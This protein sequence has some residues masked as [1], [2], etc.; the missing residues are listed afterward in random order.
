MFPR[1]LLRFLHKTEI[2]EFSSIHR[3]VHLGASPNSNWRQFEWFLYKL[4]SSVE[5]QASRA[6]FSRFVTTRFRNN[7]NRPTT[8]VCNLW[9]KRRLSSNPTNVQQL[10]CCESRK[11]KRNWVPNVIGFSGNYWSKTTRLGR[12][13]LK[14]R[15]PE[16]TSIEDLEQC[17]D[18][19]R[20]EEHC[21]WSLPKQIWMVESTNEL[22]ASSGEICRAV[23]PVGCFAWGV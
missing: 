8:L 1:I 5:K 13:L 4:T 2:I 15:G 22:L 11:T 14:K 20:S 6:E 12:V 19:D 9:R 10:N 7:G 16:E 18:V 23:R 3:L 17:I 21:F